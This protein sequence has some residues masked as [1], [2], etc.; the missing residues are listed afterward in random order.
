MPIRHVGLAAS[1]PPRAREHLSLAERRKR[2]LQVAI[3]DP[4][5]HASTMTLNP[6]PLASTPP[7]HGVMQVISK[8]GV[9]SRT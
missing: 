6:L 3:R 2:L 8:L 9:G 5:R 7:H 1:V 4:L